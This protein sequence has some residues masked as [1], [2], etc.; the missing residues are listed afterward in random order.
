MNEQW[1]IIGNENRTIKKIGERR[2][3]AYT[4]QMKNPLKQQSETH[5]PMYMRVAERS[6]GQ[7]QQTRARNATTCLK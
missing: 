2:T 3:R 6:L 1:A 4:D 5:T 7:S